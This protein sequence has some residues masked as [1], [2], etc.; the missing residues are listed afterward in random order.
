MVLGTEDEVFKKVILKL[1]EAL[2]EGKAYDVVFT[3]KT[4]MQTI[5]SVV[6]TNL[7]KYNSRRQSKAWKWLRRLSQR[8]IIYGDVLDVLAQ[9]HP[10]YVALAW[11]TFKLLFMV[12]H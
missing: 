12:G 9:H 10:E 6:D 5:M 8:L 4:D 11:G 3:Y 7:K 2:A 1:K